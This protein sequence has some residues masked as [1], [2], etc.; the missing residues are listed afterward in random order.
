MT[1]WIEVLK[2]LTD[3]PNLPVRGSIYEVR[4][5]GT[6]ES[7]GH[8]PGH[9]G[10]GS[11][12]AV[13]D[14]GCRVWLQG[15]RVRVENVDGNPIFISDGSRAWDFT[16]HVDR[17]RV[18]SLARVVYLGPS[19]FLLQRRSTAEWTGSDFAQPVD[20]V[21]T[22]DFAGRRCW[23]VRLAPPTGKPH[24]LRI[25]VD[26]ESGQMLANRLEETGVGS[27]F[28][29]LVVGEP[30]DETLF[31][32]DGPAYTSEQY[33]QILR[34]ERREHQLQQAQWFAE[35]VTATALTTRVP[36]DFTPVDARETDPDTGGFDAQ[37]RST[38][39]SRRRR[40][41]EGW[42]PKW[43]ILHYAWSTPEWDWAAGAREVDLDDAAVD[44]LQ[45]RLHP[46][47]PVDRVR[48]IDPA[49]RPRRR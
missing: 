47:E 37:N 43:G 9:S 7:F 16:G 1:A 46:S 33:Q 42:D 48:R 29:D 40:R 26:I 36:I 44:E 10:G 28:V 17:P 18:G 45:Q 39:L 23:T 14:T 8:E 24:P 2:A 11:M 27:E 35:N 31:V 30:L 49:G 4:A 41:T 38:M 20:Q 6:P 25:W 13:P 32:W 3:G 15:R 21:E 5:E 22:T 12:L 19:Q 34:D